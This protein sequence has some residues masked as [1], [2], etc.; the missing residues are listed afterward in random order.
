MTENTNMFLKFKYLKEAVNEKPHEDIEHGF[1]KQNKHFHKRANSNIYK[2]II[3]NFD[4]NNKLKIKNKREKILILAFLFLTKNNFFYF[5]FQFCLGFILLGFSLIC[6]CLEYN[7]I[8]SNISI[9]NNY[10]NNSEISF[11]KPKIG[12]FLNF[13][14]LILISDL[15]LKLNIFFILALLS[16]KV[17]YV[18]SKS[19]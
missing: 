19:M 11:N 2:S 13:E 4:D 16:Y 12:N 17:F 10:N 5:L 8:N 14:N 9:N 7:D 6:I 15:A 3:D 1:E 18:F